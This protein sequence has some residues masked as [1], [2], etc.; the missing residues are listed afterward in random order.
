MI[1]K[2][3]LD[4]ATLH[5]Q[6]TISEVNAKKWFNEGKKYLSYEYDTACKRAKTQY[7]V[8]NPDTIFNLPS[9]CLRIKDVTDKDNQPYLYFS[10]DDKEIQFKTVGTYN[11]VCLFETVDYKGATASPEI[12]TEYCP[13]LA[14]Y[15]AS[16]ELAD[17]K[18]GKADSLFSEFLSSAASVDRRL[19]RMSRTINPRPV[20]RFR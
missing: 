16:R 20:P 5:K 19:K 15:I 18:S 12:R 10:A 7:V 3:I 13:A 11:V 14:K 2:D 17:L 4:L 9:G 8:D 6:M 1:W